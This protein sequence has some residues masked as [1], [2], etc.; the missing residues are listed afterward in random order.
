MYYRRDPQAK[1]SEHHITR[2]HEINVALLKAMAIEI[3][4]YF[5]ITKINFFVIPMECAH[6][7][8]NSLILKSNK[9]NLISCRF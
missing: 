7:T 6:Y 2:S 5:S 4:Y 3:N 9:I 1:I 8:I